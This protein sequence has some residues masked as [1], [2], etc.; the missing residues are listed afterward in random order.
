MA[1]ELEG[2]TWQVKFSTGSGRIGSRGLVDPG[3]R[4]QGT[5]TTPRGTYSITEGFG[6]QATETRIPYHR[7]TAKD[8]W[9]GDPDSTSYN[10]MRTE[11]GADFPLVEK[12]DHGS[13]HLVNYPTQ[14]AEALVINFNR[15]PAV[16]WR[17]SGIFLH[18]NG[19]GATA[20]CVSVPRPVM[21][22]IMHWIDPSK[23]PKIAIG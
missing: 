23:N 9:V 1:W 13:E 17:G 11:E 14:Y 19:A 16:P 5:Y 2:A 8:W 3:T 22:Q 20:G 4:R 12:G 7:V 15:W 21:D 10:S 18:V 6:L